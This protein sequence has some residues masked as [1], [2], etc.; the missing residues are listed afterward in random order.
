MRRWQEALSDTGTF[1]LLLEER[2]LPAQVIRTMAQL[3]LGD[4]RLIKAR[5]AFNEKLSIH[6]FRRGAARSKTKPK[7]K[8]RTQSPSTSTSAATN[9]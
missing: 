1:Y 3:G 7:T 8:S 9:E 5:K 6:R 2:N 4:H